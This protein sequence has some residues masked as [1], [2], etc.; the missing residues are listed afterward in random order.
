MD[1]EEKR[2]RE[3]EREIQVGE[4]LTD[5][6]TIYLV[7]FLSLESSNEQPRFQ[8]RRNAYVIGDNVGKIDLRHDVPDEL[9]TLTF[10]ITNSSCTPDCFASSN[11]YFVSIVLRFLQLVASLAITVS[12]SRCCSQIDR[13]FFCEFTH[14]KNVQFKKVEPRRRELIL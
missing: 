6:D 1:A 13:E 3:R 11:R 9:H 4:D 14:R 10:R 5:D 2:E 8:L 12:V 7:L